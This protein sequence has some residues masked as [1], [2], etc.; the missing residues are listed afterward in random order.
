MVCDK[1]EE[2]DSVGMGQST[3]TDCVGGMGKGQ[4]AYRGET[5]FTPKR[6]PSP[7]HTCPWPPCVSLPSADCFCTLTHPYTVTLLPFVTDHFREGKL[8]D[9]NVKFLCTFH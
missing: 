5:L 1:R 2:G 6:A 4:V 7:S 3:E 9:D 8:I